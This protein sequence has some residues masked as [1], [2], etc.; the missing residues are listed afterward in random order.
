[1]Y[2]GADNI[3][4]LGVIEDWNGLPYT[5]YYG[6]YCNFVNGTSGELWPPIH[7]YKSISMFV[8]DTC[9]SLKLKFR[10]VEDF[11]GIQ[12]RMY[13]GDESVFDNGTKYPEMACFRGEDVFPSG[14]RD[15]SKCK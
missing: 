15:V 2:T 14:V 4:K 13:I 8:P 7:E 11:D 12:G 5:K 10:A 1:M 3:D 9:S 6:D